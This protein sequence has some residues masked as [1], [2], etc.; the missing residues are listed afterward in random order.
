MGTEILDIRELIQAAKDVRQ[1]LD[2]IVAAQK[3]TYVAG[4]ID[5]FVSIG[6]RPTWTE[7]KEMS[8]EDRATFQE[9]SLTLRKAELAVQAAIA[10]PDN[11][12][13]QEP[14]LE[15]KDK[16]LL[17]SRVGEEATIRRG[18]AS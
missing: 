1:A 14:F 15:A 16:I 13:A 8:E 5:G 7:W 3:Q 18:G 6:G 12:D 17:A 11:L 9:A 10:H 4:L 2:E